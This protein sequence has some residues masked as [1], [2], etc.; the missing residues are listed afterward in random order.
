MANDH[1]VTT[2]DGRTLSVVSR[3]REPTSFLDAD[4]VEVGEARRVVYETKRDD[5][6][7]NR[8]TVHDAQGNLVFRVVPSTTG[9]TL[10]PEAKAPDIYRTDLIDATGSRCGSMNLVRVVAGWTLGKDLLDDMLWAGHAGQSL[11]LPV[12]GTAL[13]FDRPPTPLE[14]DLALRMCVDVS[15]GLRPYIAEMN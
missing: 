13:A 6:E 7:N 2:A 14:G 8:S 15:I 3:Q 11:P 12:A 1:V 10:P 9:A 4:G 5:L